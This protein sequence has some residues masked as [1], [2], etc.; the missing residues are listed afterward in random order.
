M[1]QSGFLIKTVAAYLGI[2][3]DLTEAGRCFEGVDFL[4]ICDMVII[5]VIFENQEK[6]SRS[7]REKKKKKMTVFLQN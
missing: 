5:V 1:T 2:G 4:L 6:N 7:G 3:S